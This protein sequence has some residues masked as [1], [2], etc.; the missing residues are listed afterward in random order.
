MDLML[1]PPYR[2]HNRYIHWY[3]CQSVL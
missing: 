2:L 3:L 1:L